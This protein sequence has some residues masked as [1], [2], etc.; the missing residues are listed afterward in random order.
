MKFA[1]ALLTVPALIGAA[2]MMTAS[3]QDRAVPITPGQMTESRVFVENR[4]RETAIPVVVHDIASTSPV[5]GRRVRQAWEY[6][7]V[8]LTHGEDAARVLT[9]LG[10]DGWEVTGVQLSTSV[11]TILLL[12]RPL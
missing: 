2:A 5:P 1:V 4:G 12:K 8:N 10:L 9:P 6:R 7:L 3:G 11:N